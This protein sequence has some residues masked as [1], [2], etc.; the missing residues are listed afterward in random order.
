MKLDDEFKRTT[1]QEF[2]EGDYV[3]RKIF[4]RVVIIVLLLIVIIGGIRSG[5][6]R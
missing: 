1:N 2:K 4:V 6:C 5:L 3:F